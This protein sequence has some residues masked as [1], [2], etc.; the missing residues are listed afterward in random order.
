MKNKKVLITGGAGYIGSRL[1][2]KVIQCG[3]YVNILDCVD[4]NSEPIKNILSISNT[5]YFKGSIDDEK[6]LASCTKEVDFVIH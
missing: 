3:Y 5:T 2:E 4:E 1:V 6:I